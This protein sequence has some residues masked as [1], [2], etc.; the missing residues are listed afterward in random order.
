M[1]RVPVTYPR[2]GGWGRTVGREYVLDVEQTDHAQG[3]QRLLSSTPGRG[4]A[5][6]LMRG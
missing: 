3:R 1:V 6:N 2:V 4:P 5:H